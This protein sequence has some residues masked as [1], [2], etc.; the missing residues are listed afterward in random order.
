MAEL[1]L[2]LAGFEMTTHGVIGPCTVAHAARAM[3]AAYDKPTAY[4]IS[5]LYQVCDHLHKDAATDGD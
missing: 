2:K 5:D 1:A 3:E 4:T